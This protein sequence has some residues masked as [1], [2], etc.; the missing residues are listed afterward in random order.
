MITIHLNK[1]Y[2]LFQT[3][4]PAYITDMVS[5]SYGNTVTTVGDY[6]ETYDQAVNCIPVSK[7]YQVRLNGYWYLSVRTGIELD[8]PEV[9]TLNEGDV[10]DA[11]GICEYSGN[12][13][14]RLSDGNWTTLKKAA[15][16]D[17]FL[18]PF[19]DTATA[20]GSSG[21]STTHSIA[22]SPLSSISYKA[23]ETQPSSIHRSTTNTANPNYIFS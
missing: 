22:P 23:T 17:F 1:L 11:V 10:I 5:K 3:K 4:D 8:S 15:S 2:D 14:V 13:R 6:N 9:Y 12:I 7:K 18:I 19:M 20:T 21:S 16:K